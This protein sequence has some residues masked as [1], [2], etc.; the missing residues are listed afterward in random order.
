MSDLPAQSAGLPA[1]VPHD[2]VLQP[3]QSRIF[4]IP[5]RRFL[6]VR[7][8]DGSM[9]DYHIKRAAPETAEQG[10]QWFVRN[11][12]ARPIVVNLLYDPENPVHDEPQRNG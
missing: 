4:L 9:C 8:Q 12:D 7:A 11:D 6:H 3:G 10:A 2:S 5:K 1:E